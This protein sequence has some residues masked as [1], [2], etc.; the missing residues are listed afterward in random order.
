MLY[1]LCYLKPSS[2]LPKP[3]LLHTTLCQLARTQ[4]AMATLFP[5]TVANLIIVSGS[6]YVYTEATSLDEINLRFVHLIDTAKT[7][8]NTVYVCSVLPTI[9]NKNNERREKAYEMNRATCEEKDAT[10]V[11]VICS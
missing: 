1:F 7:A 3:H 5:W 10:F 4:S 2:S 9:D 6:R 11:K 8:A